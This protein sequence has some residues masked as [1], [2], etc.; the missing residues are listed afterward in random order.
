MIFPCAI[1]IEL[2]PEEK[3]DIWNTP[4]PD[5]IEKEALIQQEKDVGKNHFLR[6]RQ[7]KTRKQSF[8]Y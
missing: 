4:D 2:S 8:I 5:L 7:N 1:Q 6:H 3:E